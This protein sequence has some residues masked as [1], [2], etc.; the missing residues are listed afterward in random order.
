MTH[1]QIQERLN[2][3]LDGELDASA[4]AEVSSHLD[5]CAACKGDVLRLRRLGAALFKSPAAADSRSTEAFV[6]RVMARVE[7]E[8]VSPWE[9][10]AARFLAPAFG[11]ALAGL[12]FTI[13][14]P[15]ADIDAPL[16]VVASVDADSVLGVAP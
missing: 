3:W 15:R 16:G 10:F 7:A 8:S 14:V 1:E 12:I 6:A 9:K 13:Y 4:F 5:A 11:L 2:E